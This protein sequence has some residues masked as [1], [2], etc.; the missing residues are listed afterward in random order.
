MR[1]D[2]EQLGRLLEPDRL[3]KAGFEGPHAPVH[4]DDRRAFVDADDA[5]E[6]FVEPDDIPGPQ[7]EWMF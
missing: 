1:R 4:D 7:P 6:P 3:V 5:A 2:S